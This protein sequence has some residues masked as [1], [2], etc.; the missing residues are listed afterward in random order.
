MEK[1]RD[2]V[3]TNGQDLKNVPEFPYL[4]F[5]CEVDGSQKANLE[6]RLAMAWQTFGE[7]RDIWNRK[8]ISINPRK[9]AHEAPQK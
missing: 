3:H 2:T 7:L 9:Q 8:A 6:R 5:I 4:G 1:N